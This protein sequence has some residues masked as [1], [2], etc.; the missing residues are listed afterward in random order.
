[1]FSPAANWAPATSERS[2]GRAV[3]RSLDEMIGAAFIL[4]AAKALSVASPAGLYRTQQME[5]AGAL[6]LWP[7]GHF[8]YALS[9][10]AVDEEGAGEWLFDHGVVRLI[11]KPMPKSP[12]FE[13]VRDDPA[14]K[15][16]LSL[17][18]Q[19]PGFEWGH[20][21]EAI[22]QAESGQVFEIAADDSGHVDLSGKPTIKAVALEIPVFGPTGQIFPLTNGRG[23][24]L[25]FRFHA[26]DLGKARFD[27]EPL[28]R[29]GS[30]LLLRR[31]DTIIRFVKVRP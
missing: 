15:G 17:T 27:R 25:T 19:D 21:L 11:S 30:T 4:L 5:V 29:E 13:L 2:L 23:H 31:Y 20:P 24:K 22:A 7:D 18:L 26:N 9:Y 28:Q 8:R 12:S 3:D 1:M 6:Q 10:G 14:P 16:E